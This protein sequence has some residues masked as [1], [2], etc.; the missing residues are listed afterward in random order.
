MVCYDFYNISE[1]G[2]SHHDRSRPIWVCH[3]I[4]KIRIVGPVGSGK[5]T[6]ARKISQDLNIPMFTLDDMVW[7]RGSGGDIRNSDEARDLALNSVIQQSTWII[8]GTHLGWSDRSFDEAEQILFLNPSVLTRVYRF[9]RRFIQQKRGV[10]FSSYLPTWRMY[11]RMFKWTYQYE[12]IYK[13]QVR[14][15]MQNFTRD[16]IEIRDGKELEY[17]YGK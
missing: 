10:E 1:E 12:M 5:S 9:S 3:M 8:E 2:H 7:S 14:E 16:A 17:W 6:L 13:H 4:R 15:I 11:G